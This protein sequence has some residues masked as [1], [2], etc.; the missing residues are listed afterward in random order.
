[1]ARQLR[2]PLDYALLGVSL[3][4]ALVFLF[5]S[6]DGTLRQR[7][8]GTVVLACTLCSFVGIQRQTPL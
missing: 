5:L 8:L 1:V 4:A 2:R 3:A 6:T 7:A